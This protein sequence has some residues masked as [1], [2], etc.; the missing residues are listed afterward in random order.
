MVTVEVPAVTDEAEKKRLE[1]NAKRRERYAKQKE[2]T[3]GSVKPRKVNGKKPEPKTMDNKQM[4]MMILSISA[5]VSSRPNCEQWLLTEAE[6]D[7]IT[8]PL[9]AMLSESEALNVINENSNQI[10]L[11]FACITVFAPRIIVTVQK[12]KAE[13][14]R[15]K[16]AKQHK[17]TVTE[18]ENK[19]TDRPNTVK[20]TANSEGV[21]NGL[22]FFG[23][24]TG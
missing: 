14:E 10:A 7:S 18:G 8:K 24:P 17:V 9:V 6:V 13:K 1:R 22:S 23:S 20:P 12:M 4:N 11:V 15:E 21:S 16:V 2:A 3:G 19:G 5:L